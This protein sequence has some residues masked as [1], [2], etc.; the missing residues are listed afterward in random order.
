MDFELQRGQWPVD[1]DRRRILFFNDKA[2]WLLYQQFGARFLPKLYTIP[3]P[4]QPLEWKLESMDALAFF[5]WAG[6]QWDARR[7]GEELTLELVAGLI[8]PWNLDRI[9]RAVVFAVVGATA[10]PGLPG[11]E[12]ADG[13]AAKPAAGTKAAPKHPGPSK[14]STSLKRSAS[15]TRSSAGRRTSSGKP[16]RAR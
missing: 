11:K 13:V 8:H 9:F 15:P 14:V 7:H 12:S 6:L 5:L 16:R 1:L 2:T 3:N 4:K 10:A